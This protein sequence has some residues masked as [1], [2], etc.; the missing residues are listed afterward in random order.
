MLAGRLRESVILDAADEAIYKSSRRASRNLAPLYDPPVPLTPRRSSDSRRD[1]SSSM[2][3]V[4]YESFRWM[5]EEEDIN[6]KLVLDD[7][8][9]NLDG[10]VIPNADSDRRPSFR[11]QLSISKMPFGRNSLSSMQPLS[12]KFDPQNQHIRTKSRAMSLIAP[13]HM[14]QSSISSIDPH[15]TH[16]QDPEARLK[17]RVYLASPQKFD[18]AI[19]FGF[20]SMDGATNDDKENKFPRR[21]RETNIKKS[22]A[23]DKSFLADD[24][25]S[26]FDD[27]T[28][29]VDPDSPLTPMHSEFRSNSQRPHIYP[30]SRHAKTSSDIPQHFPGRPTIKHS[31]SY[32]QA[33]AGSREMTLRMTLT[34]PD[35]RADE[36]QLYGWQSAKSMSRDGPVSVD[37]EEKYDVK[38]PFGGMDGWAL[39]EK[40]STG[41]KKFWNKVKHPNAQRRIS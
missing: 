12:P 28:S 38:G 41:I 6:S 20:P 39:P 2:A 36:T 10:A 19:E 3:A 1:S 34:R 30:L 21:S 29:M 27:D 13:R 31:D 14:P 35:L 22:F 24:T 16:Y 5:D 40:E 25:A 4:M 17:L 33:M 11:R 23:T 8:H 37:V 7:Y 15:A 18:E 9:A 26:L 32:S